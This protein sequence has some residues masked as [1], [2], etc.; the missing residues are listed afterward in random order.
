MQPKAFRVVV[1]ETVVQP[2][3]VAVVEAL[4]L[5]LPLQI[6][7]SLRDEEKLRMRLLQRGYDIAPVFR[8]GRSTCA[9]APR[10]LEDRADE[11]HRHVAAYAVAPDGYVRERRDRCLS[12]RGI[13]CIELQH[14]RP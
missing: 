8:R 6:P 14:I 10:A 11:Q 9:A 13:K 3:V 4:L 5:K 12:E 1:S 7:V 2:L